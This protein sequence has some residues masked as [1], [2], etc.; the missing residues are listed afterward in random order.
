[1]LNNQFNWDYIN[2]FKNIFVKVLGWKSI[3]NFSISLVINCNWYPYISSLASLGLSLYQENGNFRLNKLNDSPIL[4]VYYKKTSEIISFINTSTY[5]SK[6]QITV[7]LSQSCDLP[8]KNSSKRSSS[9][10]RQMTWIRN[11]DPHKTRQ[12]TEKWMQVK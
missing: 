12:S 5:T 10:R 2:I 8:C 11:S 4:L 3:I 1:M 9:E 7:L 6:K